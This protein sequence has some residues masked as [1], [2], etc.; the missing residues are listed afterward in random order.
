M[1]IVNF[2]NYILFLILLGFY[3]FY[4]LEIFLVTDTQ[5]LEIKEIINDVSI[6]I[7]I[8]AIILIYFFSVSLILIKEFT[9]I[10][11]HF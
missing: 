3:Y 8:I 7:L 9:S 11:Y 10:R 6:F 2:S 5:C 4:L 1:K